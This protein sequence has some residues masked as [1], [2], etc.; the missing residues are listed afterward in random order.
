M[1][2]ETNVEA[3]RCLNIHHID[4]EIDHSILLLLNYLN[5]LHDLFYTLKL[6]II[7][8][9]WCPFDFTAQSDNKL[10][11]YICFKY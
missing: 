1:F 9:L 7:L 10:L 5:I 2:I 8:I 11:L 4:K 6:I 3:T